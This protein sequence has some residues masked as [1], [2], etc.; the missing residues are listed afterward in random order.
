VVRK[1]NEKRQEKRK[2]ER[3]GDLT[4]E[5]LR[6]V[7]DEP[8]DI[9]YTLDELQEV[10]IEDCEFRNLREHTMKYFRSELTS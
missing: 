7:L 9:E 6:F 1:A 3:R 2:S 4:K 8:T 5:E 10:F